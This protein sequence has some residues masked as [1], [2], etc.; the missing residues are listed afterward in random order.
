MEGPVEIVPGVYGLGSEKV[1]WY[2]VEHEGRLTAVDAG[3]PAFATTLA[4]DLAK[5]GK[6]IDDVDAVVLTHSDGD[7][8]GLAST[9]QRR[10]AR[11]CWCTA[12]TTRRCASPA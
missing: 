10:L 9:F 6:Q 12:T 2:L 3:L 11:A 1:N 7:H 4:A 5:I 8:T